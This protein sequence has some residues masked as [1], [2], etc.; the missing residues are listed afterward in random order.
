MV[1]SPE[2]IG[3]LATLLPLGAI[4]LIWG[5]FNFKYG[6]SEAFT[7]SHGQVAP[8]G[9]EQVPTSTT[10]TTTITPEQRMQILERMF[11]LPSTDGT[12]SHADN[13]TVTTTTASTKK[14][15]VYAYDV[16]TKKYIGHSNG[17][18][19]VACQ[20]CSICLEDFD[21]TSCIVTGGCQH[22]YH[23]HCLLD[24]VKVDHNDCP[25]C[26]AKMWDPEEFQRLHQPE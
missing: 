24:W 7:S 18:L 12:E 26:R 3:T 21:N 13:H 20:S 1:A 10:A 19:G 14:G 11:P 4:F 25:N 17:S 2:L 15:F 16:E 22:S 23:R 8:V 5:Y 6:W 9:I